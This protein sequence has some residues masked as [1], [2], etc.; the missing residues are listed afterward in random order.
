MY[1]HLGQNT[2]VLLDDIVGI[3]DMDTSTIAKT[4][5]NFLS[6][7]EKKGDIVSVSN[8][9]PKTFIVCKAPSLPNGRIIYLSQISSPTLLK[10]AGFLSETHHKYKHEPHYPAAEWRT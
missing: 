7:A 2:V 6:T 10:R 8:E 9:L 3:F 4:T 5:R 1:L